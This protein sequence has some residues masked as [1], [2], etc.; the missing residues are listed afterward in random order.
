[1]VTEHRQIRSIFHGSLIIFMV[2]DIDKSG[3]GFVYYIME[4][5]QYDNTH[6]VDASEYNEW[7]NT[8]D[9]DA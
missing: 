9:G 2:K 1:M 6:P 8:Y 3:T 7:I 4:D 5:G